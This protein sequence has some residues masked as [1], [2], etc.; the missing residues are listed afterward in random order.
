[1]NHRHTTHSHSTIF[2]A[3]AEIETIRDLAER[4][5]PQSE[6]TKQDYGQV[7]ELLQDFDSEWSSERREM[8]VQMMGLLMRPTQRNLAFNG[9][10]TLANGTGL[11]ASTVLLE[12][13]AVGS[14]KIIADMSDIGASP[15]RPFLRRPQTPACSFSPRTTSL[16]VIRTTT[17]LVRC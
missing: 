12:H 13:G 6:E 17:A 10:T 4:Y 5:W 8:R 2:N 9:D 3:P 15:V 7:G 16:Q 1:M 11:F 14:L